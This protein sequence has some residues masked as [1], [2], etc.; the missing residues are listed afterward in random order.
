MKLYEH[1]SSGN[2]LKCRLV[3]RALDLPYES[4]SVDLFRGETRT[5]RALRPQPRR[6]H[7]RA[8]DRRR[9]ADPRVGRDPPPPRRG[10]A[11]AA[12]AG[13]DRAHPRAPVDVLR[14]EPD[15]GRPGDGALHQARGPRR[16]DAARCSRTGSSAAATRSPRSTAASS[17][18]RPF[19]AGDAFTVADIARLRLRPLRRRRGRRP[20]RLRRTSP[21]GSTA[22]RPRP[23]S[24][25]D[26]EPVP[27]HVAGAAALRND[28]GIDAMTRDRLGEGRR[29]RR[30][31]RR[32]DADRRLETRRGRRPPCLRRRLCRA[33]RP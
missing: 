33:S 8:R 28:F 10:H 13:H 29:V 19:L 32:P 15:R 7:P 6:P 17:D 23:G 14:A 9:R 30:C 4:V 2:C 12:G 1:G 3:L 25:N 24:S 21:P 26:L 27:A 16:D 22:S 18:G 11:A 5:A 20:A 31:R